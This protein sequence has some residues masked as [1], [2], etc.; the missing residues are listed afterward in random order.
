[1]ILGQTGR[2]GAMPGNSMAGLLV[3]NESIKKQ[4]CK[5]SYSMKLELREVDHGKVSG[6]V[7]KHAHHR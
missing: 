1:M 3:K 4:K 7:G 2:A 5:I 6:G